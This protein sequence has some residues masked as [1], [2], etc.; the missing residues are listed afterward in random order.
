[1]TSARGFKFAL[2]SLHLQASW[3]LEA[4]K[5]EVAAAERALQTSREQKD[6]LL[7]RRSELAA[8]CAA[9]TGERVDPLLRDL[10]L[11]GFADVET[12]LMEARR[13][14]DER[15]QLWASAVEQ[16]VRQQ[17]RLDGLDEV[18]DQQRVAFDCEQR[19]AQARRSDDDWLVRQSVRSS[20]GEVL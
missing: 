20:M 3:H 10:Q 5:R 13:L 1:M 6:V 11:R 17:Q 15:Y 12:H 9:V 2:E 4:V 18:R 16:C 14:Y 8:R 7:E 19:R